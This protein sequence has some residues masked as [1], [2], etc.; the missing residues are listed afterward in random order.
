MVSGLVEG[1][2]VKEKKA[3]QNLNGI[4][5]SAKNLKQEVFNN[6]DF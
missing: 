6:K 3:Q 2:D 1:R 4:A 5:F